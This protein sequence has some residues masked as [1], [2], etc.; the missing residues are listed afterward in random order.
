MI[1]QQAC[2][3]GLG[4]RGSRAQNEKTRHG[5]ASY[6]PIAGVSDH[7]AMVLSEN[8]AIPGRG[9]FKDGGIVYRPQS[10][11]LSADQVNARVPPAHATHNVAVD[12]RVSDQT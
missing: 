4:D 3:D 5:K 10:N 8:D 7:C 1:D 6:D 9:P 2:V 11:F 12:I